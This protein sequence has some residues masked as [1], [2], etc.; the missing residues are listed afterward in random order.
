LSN[1]L[2]SRTSS[3][4]AIDLLKADHDKV[5][6]LFERVKANED[7]N[8]QDVFRKIKEELDVHAHIEEMVFYPHLLENGDEELQKIVREGIEEHR[9]VKMFLAELDQLSGNAEKFKAKL[10]VLMED[11]EHHVEEEEGEMFPMVEDQIGEEM[12]VRLGSLLEAEKVR[13]TS[14]LA[15]AAGGM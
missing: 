3:E 7:G 12:L 14:G 6:E 2:P 4:T 8:N 9:Q 5:E 15:S 1:I 13:F 11:V 10:Q